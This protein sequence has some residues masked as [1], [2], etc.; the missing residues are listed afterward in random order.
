M[1]LALCAHADRYKGLYAP[2]HQKVAAS[3]PALQ[4]HILL[5]D[6]AVSRRKTAVGRQSGQPATGGPK[7]LHG[8]G[9]ESMPKLMTGDI[10]RGSKPRM[11]G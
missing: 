11:R 6:A 7:P 8:N 10:R 1:T 4:D 5:L 2:G 3:G 9:C